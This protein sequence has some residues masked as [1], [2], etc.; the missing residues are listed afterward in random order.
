MKKIALPLL[1]LV[2]ACTA[3]KTISKATSYTLLNNETF[4]ITEISTDKSY[5]Y[6]PKNAVQVGGV[7]DQQGPMNERRYLNALTG[8]N[9]EKITYSRSGSCCA[10]KSKNALYG[11]KV[12]LDN[13]RVTYPGLGD[14]VSIYINMYDQGELKAPVGFKFKE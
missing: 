2:A 14:T 4:K 1:L 5:G 10:V 3:P 8:P 7:K 13:Y 12:L 11:D 6:S 9:G